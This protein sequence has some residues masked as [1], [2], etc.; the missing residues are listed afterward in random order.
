MTPEP[1]QPEGL[2]Y[3]EE[4]YHAAVRLPVEER[5]AF[6]E[7]ACAGNASLRSELDSL[8][9]AH[10][11]AGEFLE[12]PALGIAAALPRDAPPSRIGRQIGRY[13]IVSSLGAGGMGEVYRA[14]DPRLEREVAIKILPPHLTGDPAALTRFKRE[15]KAVAALSHP[16][17]LALHDFDS[18]GDTHFA[19]MELL[20]GEALS[21]RIAQ[22]PIPWREAAGTAIAVADGLAAAHKKGIVH[23][24]IKPDN[25]FLTTGGHVKILDFGIARVLAA[26]HSATQT[27]A[28]RP[29]FAIGTMGYMAPEQLRG[30]SVEPPADLFSLGCVLHEMVTAK[31][32]FARDTAAETVAAILTAEPPPL[33]DS[34]RGVPAALDRVVQRCLRKRADERFQSAPELELELRQVHEG[35]TGTAI[36]SSFPILRR[37]ALW[38]AAGLAAVALAAAVLMRPTSGVPA[39]STESLAILPIANQSGDP[40]LDYV[41]DG[42]TENLINSMSQLRQLKVMARTSA[43]R[44]KGRNVDPQTAGRELKVR[45]VFTGKLVRQ[46]E[47]LSI[48]VDLINVDDG[49]ELWGGHYN[50]KP[51]N[52]LALPEAMSARISDSLQLK[53][54]P[55][56]RKQSTRRPTQNQE[57]Y[58]LYL[59]GNHYLSRRDWN[60][61]QA[62]QKAIDYFQQAIEQD[63]L[64]AQAY[65]GLARSY[66]VAPGY[67]MDSRDSALKARA[68]AMK[69]LEIDD[70]TTGAHLTLAGL[71]ESQWNWGEAEKRYRRALE[72]NPSS[73]DAHQSYADF[74]EQVGK[75]QESLAEIRRAYE[76][77]PLSPALMFNLGDKLLVN[78]R[79]DEAIQQFRKGLEV[80][81]ESGVDMVHIALILVLQNKFTEAVAE[82]DRAGRFM[83]NSSDIEALRGYAY[84]HTGRRQEALNIARKLTDPAS[85][86]RG[87]GLGVPALY[88]G[89]G[90]KDRAFEALNRSCDLKLPLI[91]FVKVDPMFDPLR[92]DPRYTALLRRMNLTP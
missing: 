73:A 87:T 58:R 35:S 57:A 81:P 50:E 59:L 92:S 5:A 55:A 14:E 43:F 48:Q 6:L 78:R 29:G 91:S 32:L 4:L 8:L 65:E 11:R 64:Y 90:D 42:I 66:S 13:R 38:A 60:D 40:D 88:V 22:G 19:V 52:L 44:Y 24:D 28:T 20:Q 2:P 15:A 69:A 76:L 36:A 82:L 41:S 10:G 49:V 67:L 37:P 18:D 7:Q 89:L 1:A 74:L 9:D 62:V 45:R 80:S 86:Y 39:A 3:L 85:T 71:E 56:E 21:K 26:S 33:R 70:T 23:R 12:E 54:D 47:S 77:D 61:R 72:L 25:I 83:K 30:E 63:P 68:A 27:Q 46:G 75:V 53:L 16:N 31:R 34:V 79:Y 84:A 51:S 17:I